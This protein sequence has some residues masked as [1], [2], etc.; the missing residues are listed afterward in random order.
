MNLK[1]VIKTIYP[2]LSP[3]LPRFLTNGKLRLD[4]YSLSELEP[5][6]RRILYNR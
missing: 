3:M 5:S 1:G 4:F 2:G 6:V